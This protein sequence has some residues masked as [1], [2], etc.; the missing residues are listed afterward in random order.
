MNISVKLELLEKERADLLVVNLFE[1]IKKPLRLRSGQAG[2]SIGSVD[3]ALGGLISKLIKK[4][5]FEG[6]EGETLNFHTHGKIPAERVLIVG[7]GKE[8]EFNLET[9]RR[10]SGTVIQKA[11]D[12]SAKKVATILHGAGIGGLDTQRTTVALVEGTLLADY[13]FLKY[14]NQKERKQTEKKSIRELLILQK[15]KSNLAKVK[16]GI[17]EG[18]ILAQA[19][20]LVRDLVNEPASNYTPTHLKLHAQKLSRQNRQI[21][22]KIYDKRKLQRMGAGG[23]LGVAR[24]SDE[25]PYLIHLVYKPP[26]AVSKI[27]LVG[28]GITFDTGGIQLKPSEK[29]EQMKID[30]AG[31]GTILGVFSALPKLRPY[32]EVHGVIAACENMLSSRA[33]KPGDIVSSLSGKTIE[34]LNT[35][36]EG[37]VILADALTY[38]QKQKP[39]FI[40]DLATLT[41]ACLVALGEQIGGAMT[42]NSQSLKKLEKAAEKSGEKIWEL[43]LPKEYREGVKSEI[44]DLKNIPPTRYAGAIMGGLFLQ[45]FVGK[46]PWVHLDIAGPAFAERPFSSYVPQGGTG[47]GVRT[48]LKFLEEF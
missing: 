36:A 37:R 33:L 43:P 17:L 10:V 6:K 4:E 28:K 34:I 24:G 26:K 3:S 20:L 21:K 19:T 35:D 13:R 8:S 23:I 2:D 1:G 16:A 41:G 29:M 5:N 48:I 14:K 31:A 32:I 22:V 42:N 18:E 47:F 11:R 40:L 27:A 12:F 38:A 44:A 46:T 15:D 9:V 39:K 30:M 45:E 25:P 7:L